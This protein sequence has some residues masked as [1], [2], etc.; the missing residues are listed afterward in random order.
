[1]KEMDKKTNTENIQ[2][3]IIIKEG[4]TIYNSLRNSNIKVYTEGYSGKLNLQDKKCLSLY[5]S[6]IDNKTSL[7]AILKSLGYNK[8]VNFNIKDTN[9]HHYED[10]F[11][12][13]TDCFVTDDSIEIMALYLLDYPLIK[14]L[15]LKEGYSIWKIK[16]AIYDYLSTKTQS[17]INEKVNQKVLTK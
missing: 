2:T 8:F 9:C 16:L 14:N 15:N 13:F 11:R 12:E 10:E 1:M 6:L 17:E 4:E 7:N 5:M 3:Q